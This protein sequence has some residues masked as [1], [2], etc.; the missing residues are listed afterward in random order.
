MESRMVTVDAADNGPRCG[1][2]GKV[3]LYGIYFDTDKAVL[4]PESAA[5]LEEIAK[6]LKQDPKVNLYVVGHTDNVGEYQ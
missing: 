3:A 5:T 6:L 2:A 4:K 1:S